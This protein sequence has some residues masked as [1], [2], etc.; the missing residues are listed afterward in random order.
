[1]FVREAARAARAAG[2]ELVDKRVRDPRKIPGLLDEMS[3]KIDI[4]WMVPDS[5]VVTAE[6]VDYLLRFSFDHNVPVFSF[7][8]KYVEM[9]AVAA[10]DVDPY[11]MGV[12]AAE[13]VNAS[14]TN[15]NSAV[16]E[17]ART[18]HLTI[19]KNVAAKMGLAIRD[20]INKKVKK[21]E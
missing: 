17:F 12:Q 7:S 3:D 8:K 10:L 2:I 6:T 18:S 4:F 14:L 9:G 19:N 16:R 13:I 11:D 1:A 21:G 5:T 15:G 20:E